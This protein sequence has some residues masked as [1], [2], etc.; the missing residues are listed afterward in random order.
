M[1]TNLINDGGK[2]DA[3]PN[4]EPTDMALALYFMSIVGF[5]QFYELNK[6]KFDRDGNYAFDSQDLAIRIGFTAALNQGMYNGLMSKVKSHSS[7]DGNATEQMSHLD[8]ILVVLGENG[9]GKSKI[10][11]AKI[12][13]LLKASGKRVGV[14]GTTQFGTLSEGRLSEMKGEL[15]LDDAHTKSLAEVIALLN[16]GNQFGPD[17]YVQSIDVKGSK[18]KPGKLSESK[19]NDVKSE[20][21]GNLYADEDIKILVLDEGTFA[22][23]AEL[24]AISKAAKEKGIMVLVTGDLNQQYRVITYNLYDETGKKVGTAQASSGLEDCIYGATSKLTTSMRANYRGKRNNGQKMNFE[25]NK[26]VAKFKADP[27]MNANQIIDS[28]DVV[29]IQLEYHDT[30]TGF[31]GD[32]V[33]EEGDA[34]E[35]VKKFD[36][37]SANSHNAKPNVAIITDDEAKY[38]ALKSDNVKIYRP[39]DVQGREFDYAVIDVTLSGSLYADKFTRLKGVNT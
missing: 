20:G 15:D 33:I 7:D 19:L 4:T 26:Y 18:Y 30:G 39:E 27:L 5:D 17:D 31:Y 12:V 29:D 14:V 3:D 13:E 28:G 25:I 8:N 36:Q 11:A 9:T 10:V 34:I 35:F 23:E 1:F 38:D 2:Y 37:Y 24:Q 32:R 21:L 16:S 6:S 22:S